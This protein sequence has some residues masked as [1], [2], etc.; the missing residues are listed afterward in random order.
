MECNDTYE[1]GE[2]HIQF[3]IRMPSKLE[4]GTFFHTGESLSARI[5]YTLGARVIERVAARYSLGEFD[6]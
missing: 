3:G 2:H 5:T 1:I 4:N 6:S